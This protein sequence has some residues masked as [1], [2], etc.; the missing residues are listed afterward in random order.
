LQS[1]LASVNKKLSNE[2]FISSAPSNVVELEQKKQRD[3]QTKISKLTQL[4][5][6]LIK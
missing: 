1:F 6:E 5:S 3:A 2:K 4:K